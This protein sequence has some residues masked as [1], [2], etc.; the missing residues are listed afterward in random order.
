MLWHGRAYFDN[1]HN[2]H[3]FRQL[4]IDSGP[5]FVKLGQWMCQRPDVFPPPFLAHL[6]S[7]QRAAPTHSA[8][9]THA[10][11]RDAFGG[12]EVLQTFDSFDDTP[13]AS[14]S[15]A[16]VHRAVY[17][18]EPVVVKV[19]HPNIV[20]RVR[21]DLDLLAALVRFGR[22]INN[23]YCRVIDIDRV[24]GEM[25]AQ[26]SMAHERRC[27][28]TMASNFEGNP[29][30][31]FPRVHFAS[32]AVL[33]ET[34]AVGVEFQHLGTARDPFAYRDDGE[35]Q[36][37]RL[38]CKMATM[39]AF[40]QMILHDALLHA[41][42][43]R[44]NLL[45]AVERV[46][47]ADG[48]RL[49][50]RVTLLDFG[51]VVHLNDV[52]KEA[53]HQLIVGLYAMHAD[54]TLEALAKMAMQNNTAVDRSNF[55]AFSRDV[56]TFLAQLR[57]RVHERHVSVPFIME[58]ILGMLNAN[59]LLIDAN[60]IR[61]M[62]DFV[63]ISD[64]RRNTVGDN[65]TEDTVQ[66]VLYGDDGQHFPIV[67]HLMQIPTADF[68]RRLCETGRGAPVVKEAQFT[69]NNS[70]SATRDARYAA[71]ETLQKATALRGTSMA[72]A[73]SIVTLNNA[74]D[75]ASAARGTAQSKRKRV[76]VQPPQQQN[77]VQ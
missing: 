70:L 54:T 25:M 24:M 26:C 56:H 40:F 30:V 46:A 65:L 67:E 73:G 21:S 58:S 37:A 44:G 9:D 64:G 27:L 71:V 39:A 38:L 49:V 69:A 48:E 36:R 5:V 2:A 17:R 32:E 45:Y 20:A 12:A 29:I 62:V 11:L 8:S 4:L 23:H 10:A 7:L 22:S 61:V 57:E 75:A 35:R 55:D 72:E 60:M 41:D 68:N 6:E 34:M 42:L 52:Q 53:V 66:W 51:M 59:R 33:V 31:R 28:E 14:G 16:Q 76:P 15:I 19:R 50:P 74:T 77:I 43:H 3:E 13:L 47:D 1:E 63:L 18:G